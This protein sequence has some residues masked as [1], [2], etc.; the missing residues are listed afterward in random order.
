MH[1]NGKKAPSNFDFI[2]VWAT[3][4]LC[5]FGL[6]AG[7]S[8]IVGI[9]PRWLQSTLEWGLVA[10]AKW[11]EELLRRFT[12]YRDESRYFWAI[13][14]LNSLLYGLLF[15]LVWRYFAQRR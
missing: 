14:F 1:A 7:T 3:A 8:C 11:G 9:L 10:F 4:S 12:S 13:Y 2:S 6:M 15:A 5:H